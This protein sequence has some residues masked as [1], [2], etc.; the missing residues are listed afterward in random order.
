[1]ARRFHI[2]S[3]ATGETAEKMLRAALLQFELEGEPLIVRHHGIRHEEDLD[4]A[5]AQ[6]GAEEAAAMTLVDERLRHSAVTKAEERGLLVIDLLG[7]LLGRLQEYLEAPLRNEPG[8]QHRMEGGYRRRIEAVEY[9]VKHD[10]GLGLKTLGEAQVVVVGVSRTGKT[11][12]SIYLA[13]RGFK[14]ANIPLVIG[15]PVPAEVAQVDSRRVF[16]L[17]VDPHTL[18]QIRESR[19]QKMGSRVRTGYTNIEEIQRE[20]DWARGLYRRMGWFA[21]DVSRKA[22]EEVATEIEE[23][24]QTLFGQG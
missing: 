7:P 8:I 17:Y 6:V 16:G 4:R 19:L 13:N 24:L 2:L 9:S 3:D 5:L 22:V 1:M 20:V 14:V 21:I 18:Q 15:I 23:R 11:P 12:L 10:D